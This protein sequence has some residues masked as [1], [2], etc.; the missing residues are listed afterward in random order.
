M[1]DG[2]GVLQLELPP[3]VRS[4]TRARRAAS[5]WL[6]RVG[7]AT[8]DDRWALRLAVTEAVANAVEHGGPGPV[9]VTLACRDGSALVL[10]RDRGSWSATDHAASTGTPSTTAER[11]RGLALLG[12]A[13][14]EVEVV[15]TP[16]GTA[17]VLARHLGATARASVPAS[18]R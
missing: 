1:T 16:W 4:V 17:L 9:T 15:R 11:G 13:V 10:V 18:D 6:R 5:A 3:T 8:E 12:D 7:A 14:D 2:A